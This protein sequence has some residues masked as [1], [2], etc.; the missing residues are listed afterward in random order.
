V[1]HRNF[2]INYQLPAETRCEAI[3]EEL[4][5]ALEKS[6]L[7]NLVLELIRMQGMGLELGFVRLVNLQY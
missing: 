1:D 3:Y 2:N 7:K 5:R 6:G 4:V